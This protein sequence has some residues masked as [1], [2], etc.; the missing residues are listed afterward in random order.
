MADI[1]QLEIKLA[2]AEERNWTAGL[3][4]GS[5]PWTTLGTT[6]EQCL[7]VCQNHEYIIYVSSS[8]GVANGA[9]ILHPRGLASSPYIKSVVVASTHRNRGIG[10]RLVRFAEDYFRQS[11]RHIF[12]CVS[13]FNTRA[14]PFYERLGYNRVGEFRDFVKDGE[15]EYLLYKRLR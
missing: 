2:S 7:K 11:S 6:L 15:S 13:S 9:I 1:D 10:E 4:V 12:L 14:Q 5:E 8:D 3:L